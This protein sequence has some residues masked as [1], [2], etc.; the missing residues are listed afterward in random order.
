MEY[1]YND[2]KI[3]AEII[4]NHFIDPETAQVKRLNK[5]EFISAIKEIYEK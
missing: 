1:F 2:G 4:T 3:I 5:A